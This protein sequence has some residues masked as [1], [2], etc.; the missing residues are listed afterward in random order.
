MWFKQLFASYG[1]DVVKWARYANFPKIYNWAMRISKVAPAMA[2]TQ[3]EKALADPVG[4]IED[5][6]PMNFKHFFVRR[7]NFTQPKFVLSGGY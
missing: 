6:P 4:L 7:K 2:K 5:Q 1:G 3:G